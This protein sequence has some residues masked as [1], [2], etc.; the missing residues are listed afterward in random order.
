[1]SITLA[2][3]PSRPLVA[4]PVPD[5][6]HGRGDR[7]VHAVA[8]LTICA[9]AAYLIW[10]AGWTL[11][12]AALWIALPFLIVELHNAVG[13]AVFSLS[14]WDV[15]APPTPR[16]AKH[17]LR[18]AVVIPTYNEP[19][20][21]LMPTIAASVA[22]EPAHETWVLDDGRRPE[23]QE[24]AE[25]LGARYLTRPD[26]S[27]AKAGNL[28]NALRV[29]D[30]DIFA[31]LDADHVPLAGFLTDTLGYFD[32]PTIAVVQTPQDF[33]NVD[34][35]EHEKDSDKNQTFNEQAVFYRAIG[36]GK[37]KWH[38]AF[39]CGTCA[40]IRVDAVREV[41]GV[42]TETLTEDI[43]TTIRLQRA[44]WSTVY[45]N[46]VVALGLAA[47]DAHAYMLQRRRWATGAMQVLRKERPLI[48]RGLSF[49]QRLAYAATLFAW[50][51]SWRTLAYQLIPIVILLTG[52]MPV[53]SDM[54]VF[55]PVAVTLFVMQFITLRL[56]ARGY[57]PPILSLIFETL[58]LPAVLPATLIFFAPGRAG[59]FRVT[60]KG[61]TEEAGPVRAARV[62]RLYITLLSL[63]AVALVWAGASLAGLTP[64]HYDHPGAVAGAAAFLIGN[65][66]LVIA[67]IRRIRRPRYAGERRA[68][69]R[70]PITFKGRINGLACV[71]DDVSLTGAQVH[72]EGDPV[73][74]YVDQSAHLEIDLAGGTERMDC[75]VR[76]R[77]PDGALGLSF[78]A[79]T[80]EQVTRLA[81]ALFQ[82]EPQ[83]AVVPAT[84]PAAAPAARNVA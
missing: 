17:S 64:T 60:P 19:P 59:S 4:P 73:V 49:G 44:G 28:N 76:R 18:V 7:L 58:R 61:R 29:I 24:L 56:L 35:F 34:S 83:P 25:R 48:G 63:A 67:A 45:H 47:A 12:G 10:R 31:V 32:D 33:Y 37:N 65:Q 75:I 22:L 16:T 66:L 82:Q 62:P 6:P 2:V 41:G 8:M 39:W 15:G 1:M 84:M 11:D 23:I 30:A 9:T 70:F 20:A 21:V 26:N 50:F 5:G 52:A 54:S 38:G 43:H 53:A 81:L 77:R 36:P 68:S 80:E 78:E 40:L 13:L 69:Y 57:Y 42:A 79:D 3:S 55:G 51:D 46:D 14:L 27:H 72:I 71:I 74:F